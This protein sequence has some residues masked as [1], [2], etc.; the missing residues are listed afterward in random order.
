MAPKLIVDLRYTATFESNSANAAKAAASL[1]NARAVLV[2]ALFCD[3]GQEG[4]IVFCPIHRPEYREL[5]KTEGT[6]WRN[7]YPKDFLPNF[8]IVQSL[9]IIREL[10]E[11]WVLFA[12]SS[13]YF[14][15]ALRVLWKA[16]NQD[17]R[18]I[19]VADRTLPNSQEYRGLRRADP[20]GNAD[21]TLVGVP[22]TKGSQNKARRGPTIFLGPG[23]FADIHT[24]VLP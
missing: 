17:N 5:E 16:S 12:F 3:W 14:E 22:E 21:Y 11:I 2:E 9:Q 13:S 15:R 23:A 20:T 7:K 18:F 19:A 10:E 24:R 6:L 8:T 4:N 1:L